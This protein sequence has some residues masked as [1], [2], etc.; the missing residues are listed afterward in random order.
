VLHIQ[1]DDSA[2]RCSRR[3]NTLKVS[4]PIVTTPAAKYS[5]DWLM[6]SPECVQPGDV[7]VEVGLILAQFTSIKSYLILLSR[8]HFTVQ[9]YHYCFRIRNLA[10]ILLQAYR[11]IRFCLRSPGT[12]HARNTHSC[13]VRR[14]IC[15]TVGPGLSVSLPRLYRPS[16]RHTVF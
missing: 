4:V 7:I 6:T 13:L 16:C 10:F 12:L 2:N 3:H 11:K 15:Q 5:K 1:G 14:L 9:F 8:S